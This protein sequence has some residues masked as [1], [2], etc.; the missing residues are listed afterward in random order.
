VIKKSKTKPHAAARAALLPLYCLFVSILL[1]AGCEGTDGIDPCDC[2]LNTPDYDPVLDPD[3]LY[4]GELVDSLWNPQQAGSQRVNWVGGGGLQVTD[5]NRMPL[6]N[7]GALGPPEGE[8]SWS[9]GGTYTCVGV[10][11]SA[12]WKFEEGRHVYNGEGPDFITF[13]SNFAW[14]SACNGL[15]CELAHVEVSEDGSTWYYNSA[16]EYVENPEPDQDNPNY[17][18]RS[19][20]GLHGNE[21]TWANHEK[22][23]QAQEIQTVDGVEKWVDIPCE[24]ISIYFTPTDPYLGGVNFDLDDFRSHADGS[25]WPAGG[26]MR[27]IKIIDDP[28]VLDGQDYL[29][30]WCLG[31]NLM[32]AMGINVKTD[33]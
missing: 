2:A 23:M 19:V 29:K 11:G 32:A 14:S 5:E 3:N 9:S 18:Y 30:E 27:Y 13:A 7:D 22:Q 33:T 15:V 21:P 28:A 12:A 20:V 4:L 16:E 31:A 8:G 24:C 26:K 25:P 1:I 17:E 6:K 10:G